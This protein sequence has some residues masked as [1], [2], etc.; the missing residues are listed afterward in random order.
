[1]EAVA[2][3]RSFNLPVLLEQLD[4]DELTTFKNILK[5]LCQQN[6]LQ[7]VAPAEIKE[8]D[9]RRLAEMLA[10]HC[11]RY[12]VETVTVQVFEKMNRMDLSEQ[13]K[14]E[15]GELSQKSLQEK[16]MALRIVW[17]HPAK[18]ARMEDPL[19][20]LK[21]PGEVGTAGRE[22]REGKVSRGERREGKLA[23]GKASPGERP[24]SDGEGLRVGRGFP[25]LPDGG[26]C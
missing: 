24:G 10:A 13:A 11:P 17:T 19:E 1:M 25:A 14:D 6:E 4:Q 22:R 20:H 23:E 5:N 16:P 7:R 3:S 15:L 9:G 21:D 8:A 2:P 12:W 18:C 26:L